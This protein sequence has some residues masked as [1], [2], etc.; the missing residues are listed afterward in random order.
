MEGNQIMFIDY[1]LG[2]W[3]I[4]MR[5]REVTYTPFENGIGSLLDMFPLS[6]W[7]TFQW[8]ER[9]SVQISIT[10]TI[11]QLYT[12]LKYSLNIKYF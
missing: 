3:N 8:I 9:L 7:V 11:E 4:D 12:V 6:I 2:N 5:K 10:E 1:I